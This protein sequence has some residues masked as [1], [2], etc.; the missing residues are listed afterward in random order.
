MTRLPPH[1]HPVNASPGDSSPPPV[2]IHPSG[3]WS[4]PRFPLNKRFQAQSYVHKHR[5]NAYIFNTKLDVNGED[6]FQMSGFNI[7]TKIKEFDDNDIAQMILELNNEKIK[8][9]F[10]VSILNDFDYQLPF[11]MIPRCIFLEDTYRIKS[12]SLI[13]RGITYKIVYTIIVDFRADFNIICPMNIF[14][15]SIKIRKKGIKS[16]NITILKQIYTIICQKIE[17]ENHTFMYIPEFLIPGRKYPNY[18]YYELIFLYINSDLSWA[19]VAEQGGRE[20]GVEIHP[21]TLSRMARAML[22]DGLGVQ[23]AQPG[24]GRAAAGGREGEAAPERGGEAE[25]GGGKVAKRPGIRQLAASAPGPMAM[26]LRELGLG[27]GVDRRRAVASCA[28]FTRW[29]RS[30]FCLVF[31]NYRTRNLCYFPP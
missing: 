22:N 5:C 20:F 24:S 21:S 18:V 13:L 14:E 25:I 12:L 3:G 28:S 10:K 8:F 4:I 9:E 1:S 31:G 17:I 11:L 16:Y 19:E 15:K 27:A 23:S 30:E 2:E 29:W 26:I 6:I 7:N